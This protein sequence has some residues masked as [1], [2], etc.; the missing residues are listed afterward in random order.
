[1]GPDGLKHRRRVVAGNGPADDHLRRVEGV[2]RRCDTNRVVGPE[3]VAHPLSQP[4]CALEDGPGVQGRR[5][6]VCVDRR[7]GRKLACEPGDRPSTGVGFPV[8]DTATATRPA[9]GFDDD[10]AH[11]GGVTPVPP[12]QTAVDDGPGADPRRERHVHQVRTALREVALADSPR[13]TVVDEDSRTVTAGFE[14]VDQRDPLGGDVWRTVGR[15]GGQVKRPDGADT[16][17]REFV[18]RD[19]R[20][21]TGLLECVDNGGC[22]G[23]AVTVRCRRLHTAQ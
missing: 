20:G 21:R 15:A 18:T 1:M 16:D 2:D 10:V 5:T 17:G 23:R 3:P 19:V 9:A 8:A 13:H 4:V 14:W 11:L 7:L 22:D 12:E 6:E